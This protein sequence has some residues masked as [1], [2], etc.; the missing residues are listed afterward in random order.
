MVAPPGR[1]RRFGSSLVLEL[2]GHF[3]RPAK[4]E[5]SA[6]RH[7]TVERHRQSAWFRGPIGG[8]LNPVG[9]DDDAVHQPSSTATGKAAIS[10]SSRNRPVAPAIAATGAGCPVRIGLSAHRSMDDHGGNAGHTGMFPSRRSQASTARQVMQPL[11]T[12]L[13]RL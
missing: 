13:T 1:S 5:A 12:T 3:A 2:R 11:R 7:Q 9:H 4:P 10:V 8:E 6:M